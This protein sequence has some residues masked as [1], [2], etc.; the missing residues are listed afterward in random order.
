MYL[1]S[2]EQDITVTR[3]NSNYQTLLTSTE[4]ATE[5]ALVDTIDTAKELA[6]DRMDLSEILAKIDSLI[7]VREEVSNR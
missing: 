1:N 4:M 3:G 7:Q 5:L 2:T 6:A